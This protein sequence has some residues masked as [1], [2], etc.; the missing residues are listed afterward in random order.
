MKFFRREQ[1][2]SKVT[3]KE[4]QAGAPAEGTASPAELAKTE[5]TQG[6]SNSTLA[7]QV[8]WT[9][10]EPYSPIQLRLALFGALVVLVCLIVFGSWIVGLPHHAIVDK[11]PSVDR[12]L[13]EAT[14]RVTKFD[15][16]NLASAV[17]SLFRGKLDG[18]ALQSR[19]IIYKSNDYKLSQEAPGKL[20]ALG[21][22]VGPALESFVKRH[23]DNLS[24][25]NISAFVLKGFGAQGVDSLL[26]ILG[27]GNPSVRMFDQRLAT[28]DNYYDA[29]IDIGDP[30]VAKLTSLIENGSVSEK[31]FAWQTLFHMLTQYEY[32]DPFTPVYHER[33]INV[34]RSLKS[35]IA[36]RLVACRREELA[37]MDGAHVKLDPGD[38]PYY[39]NHNGAGPD[40]AIIARL[41]TI[42]TID[43]AREEAKFSKRITQLEFER[44]GLVRALGSLS[45]LTEEDAAEM[46]RI[47]GNE[48]G[49]MRIQAAFELGKILEHQKLSKQ[50]A[51]ASIALL[52]KHTT[53]P[54]AKM[55]C[56][57]A[58]CDAA[59]SH[60]ECI[61]DLEIAI[62]QGDRD[63]L[64]LARTISKLSSGTGGRK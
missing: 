42:R 24:A 8:G 23:P 20:S 53:D 62:R 51:D 36:D 49:D 47:L 32:S 6:S 7:Q 60:P 4:S 48:D 56:V 22:G 18:P 50:S 9:G 34:P 21:P 55:A 39:F 2:K 10:A 15:S 43:Q 59:R 17:D 37:L 19:P 5:D 41:G 28:D 1:E 27:K 25:G 35:Q 30:A 26:R 33:L 12:I 40:S 46:R 14:M 13:D 38:S 57:R 58:L 63:T 64:Y 52:R 16:N 54:D 31:E 61:P 29:L 44:T 3:L 11:T 45:P